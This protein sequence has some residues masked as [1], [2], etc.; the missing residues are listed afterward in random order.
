MVQSSRGWDEAPHS[1]WGVK[2]SAPSYG[3][4]AKPTQAGPPGAAF[5]AGLGASLPLPPPRAA[6]PCDPR[7]A[8]TLRRPR[9]PLLP[10]PRWLGRDGGWTACA[11]RRRRLRWR[12]GRGGQPRERSAVEFHVCAPLALLGG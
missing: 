6:S 2:P 9:A 10:C 11:L 3:K 5:S 8:R 12:S 7:V 4:G 1:G